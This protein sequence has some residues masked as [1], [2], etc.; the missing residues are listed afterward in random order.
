LPW[1]DFRREGLSGGNT[2]FDF[3]D[4]FEGCRKL[5]EVGGPHGVAIPHGAAE[6]REITVRDTGLPRTRPALARSCAASQVGPV[7]PGRVPL[8]QHG[9]ASSGSS[10]WSLLRECGHAADDRGQDSKI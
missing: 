1:A 5:R 6:R 2:G 8:D 10:K 7:E 9:R 3:R 4:H